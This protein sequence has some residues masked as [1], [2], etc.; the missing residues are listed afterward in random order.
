MNIRQFVSFIF[1]FLICSNL[2]AN[3][4]NYESSIPG[5][6][7]N[8]PVF[9]NG[10]NV[11]ASHNSNTGVG[12]TLKIG[13]LTGGTDKFFQCFYD[14]AGQANGTG[15]GAGASYHCVGGGTTYGNYD[16]TT[17]FEFENLMLLPRGLTVDNGAAFQGVTGDDMNVGFPFINATA[18]ISNIGVG[19]RNPDSGPDQ[20]GGLGMLHNGLGVFVGQNF[21][22]TGD[23]DFSAGKK[24]GAFVV[25]TNGGQLTNPGVYLLAQNAS[26]QVKAFESGVTRTTFRSAFGTYGDITMYIENENGSNGTTWSNSGEGIPLDI[27]QLAIDQSSTQQTGHIRFEP[28]ADQGVILASTTF[29]EYHHSTDGDPDDP[30]MAGSSQ[31][32]VLIRSTSSLT[33]GYPILNIRDDNSIGNP[34]QFWGTYGSGQG[35][36]VDN[37]GCVWFYFDGSRASGVCQ[38]DQEGHL[39]DKDGNLVIV[40]DVSSITNKL[41]TTFNQK[42]Y[43]NSLTSGRVTFTGTGSQLTDDS[44]FLHDSTNHITSDNWFKPL[45]FTR[46]SSQFDKTNNSTLGNVTGLSVAL[47]SGRAYHFKAHLFVDANV[48]AGYKAAVAYSGSV[49]SIIYNIDSV[50]NA[51][52]LFDITSRQTSSG[53]S[54]GQVGCTAAEV[55]IEG[56]IVTSATGNLTVQFAQN[57]AT[58]A[59][60]SSV[61][62]GSTFNVEDFN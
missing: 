56:N 46:V 62:V 1:T 59:T 27:I 22:W 4:T 41:H 18:A 35:V 25:D 39:V 7:N 48:T 36:E 40:W 17:P 31:Y 30:Y 13:N 15:V 55:K 53:G 58:A 16:V 2:Y 23:T 61:L 32:G 11:Q 52:G 42:V 3:R 12:P 8:N 57:T 60:T 45:G 34:L 20:V 14:P 5:S 38:G 54:A 47:L 29:P 28:R 26:G 10:A 44:V 37:N 19:F 21:S 6:L 50:C 33:S 51:T 43:V 9:G 49:S 24:G